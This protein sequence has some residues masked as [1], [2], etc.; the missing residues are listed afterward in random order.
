MITIMRINI[1]LHLLGLLWETKDRK[2]I[3]EA[4]GN[5]NEEQLVLFFLKM[6]IIWYKRSKLLN[7]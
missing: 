2:K 1:F 4:C 6:N 7:E 5:N 3:E